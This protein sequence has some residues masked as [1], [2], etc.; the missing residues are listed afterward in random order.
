M[1]FSD[2]CYI[3]CTLLCRYRSMYYWSPRSCV[4]ICDLE[5]SKWVAWL[6]R[7]TGFSFYLFSFCL[8]TFQTLYHW[9]FC[10]QTEIRSKISL[11][12]RRGI[13]WLVY[14]QG[15]LTSRFMSITLRGSCIHITRSWVCFCHFSLI[16]TKLWLVDLWISDYDNIWF[17]KI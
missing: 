5:I 14:L 1:L 15:D 16:E 11:R 13:G 9:S 2:S 17:C 12:C 3:Y 6:I 8:I 4:S 10:I 7:N